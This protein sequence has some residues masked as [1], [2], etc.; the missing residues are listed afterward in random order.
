MSFMVGD[1]EL[2]GEGESSPS[3]SPVMSGHKTEESNGKSSEII[4]V[5]EPLVS[6]GHDV[7]K[8]NQFSVTISIRLEGR[9][10]SSYETKL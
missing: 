3:T 4:I 5:S 2:E 8:H 1:E 10:S 7:V 6:D 9:P